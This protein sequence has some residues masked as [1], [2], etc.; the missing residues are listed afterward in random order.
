MKKFAVALAVLLAVAAIPAVTQEREDRALLPWDQ[1]RS[2]INEVSG[3]R[4]MHAVLEATPYPRVRSTS[5][6]EKGPYRETETMLRLAREFGYADAQIEIFGASGGMGGGAAWSPTQAELWLAGPQVE[7]IADAFDIVVSV[8]ANSES[9]DV[10]ADL[11]D[12]GI[13]DRPEHYAGKNVA[14]KVVLG[15]ASP[16]TLQRLAVFERGAAGVIG[17]SSSHGDQDFDQIGSSNITAT[18][19]P[20]AKPGMRPG[21]GWVVSTRTAHLLAK[22]IGRGESLKVRSIIKASTYPVRQEAVW[23]RIPGDGSSTQAVVVSGHLYEGITKQG[24][25]DDM[26]GCAVSLEF[27][28]AL[29]KLIADGKLP[30]PKRDIYFLWV[31]EISGSRAWLNQH[32]D[33]KARLVANL[34]FDMEAIGLAKS[35]S[36]WTMVRTPDTLPSFLNDVAEHFMRLIAEV[37]RERIHYRG[38]GYGPAVPVWA[39]RGS[40]DPFYIAIDRYYGAS[41]HVV[42]LG[43]HIPAVMFITWPD[44]W[45]HTS[46]DTPDKLDS[47]QFKRVGVVGAAAAAAIAAADDELALKIAAESIGNGTARAGQVQ[48]RGLGYLADVTDASRLADAY[49]DARTAVRH[50]MDIEK[51]TVRSAGILMSAPAEAEKR[52]ASLVAS[53]DQ[54]A[55]ALQAE[56][57]AFAR[58]KAEQLKTRFVEPA[59][60]DLELKAARM[61][62][63]L[64]GGAP[65]MPGFGGGGR[66]G[67]AGQPQ[68]DP[69]R[70]ALM[71]AMRRV[72]N[73]GDIPT[74]VGQKK[75]VLEI[76]DFLSGAYEPVPLADVVGYFEAAQKLGTI[77]ISEKPETVKKGVKAPVNR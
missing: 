72:P 74:L 52:L 48:K 66:G 50:Q 28:R 12:V 34:N 1:L 61:M 37:N 22:R 63:E 49:K 32:P 43:E 41:D 67:Q 27:G 36:Y 8:A 69:E 2:I 55:A 73:A 30:K 59:A 20:T 58:L 45:Y 21:F 56:V 7:K 23:A 76:R 46:E 64:V 9:G 39:P 6:L 14:G 54:R 40:R 51:Q 3:E 17:Y 44:L 35:G 70:A 42:F 10:T 29:I 77:K 4:A 60:S 31:P 62:P 57:G 15:N 13:G 26:S 5:E 38:T 65:S 33:I 75:S 18:V 47:T 16:G 71:A 25:N 24:A 19:P 11:V 68:V 53:L